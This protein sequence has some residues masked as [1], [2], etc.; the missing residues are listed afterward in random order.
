MKRAAALEAEGRLSGFDKWVTQ[1]T[2]RLPPSGPPTD[3]QVKGTRELV[4]ELNALE[5]LAAEIAGDASKVLEFTPA[6]PSRAGVPTPRSFDIAIRDRATGTAE[7]LVEAKTVTGTIKDSKGLHSSISAAAQ[8][9]P[10]DRPKPVKGTPK[11]AKLIAGTP[12]P[13]GSK[14]AAV[15]VLSWPPSGG[16]KIF[17]ADGSWKLPIPGGKTKTGHIA[18]D[19][20][21]ELNSTQLDDSGAQ[22]LDRVRVVDG[23]GQRLFSL[24]NAPDPASADGS[25]HKWERD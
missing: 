10:L 6:P 8:K 17:Q 5:S 15:V 14:E 22:F 11:G 1:A 24:T 3:A 20:A 25:R 2:E 21:K 9:L 19:L 13:A 4:G 18:D 12:L 23:D 16:N 7:H